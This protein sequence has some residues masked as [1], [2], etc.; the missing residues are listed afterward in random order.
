M[1]RDQGVCSRAVNCAVT[2]K[3]VVDTAISSCTE[4]TFWNHGNAWP[5]RFSDTGQN[6]AQLV[7]SGVKSQVQYWHM[8]DSLCVAR[9]F[10]LESAFSADSFMLFVHPPCACS[11]IYQH[12][13]AWKNPEHWQPYHCLEPQRYCDTLVG[14]RNWGRSVFLLL[15]M[16]APNVYMYALTLCCF[17]S[18]S[19]KLFATVTEGI[20]FCPWKNVPN[21][22][23]LQ[24]DQKDSMACMHLR[25]SQELPVRPGG[26]SHWPLTW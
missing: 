21:Q 20:Y 3:A 13:S 1:T 15:R 5:V 25:F 10:V 16:D 14:S 24:T 26:H 8:F 9:I 22:F 2:I 6:V 11:H 4:S 7:N 23:S 18:L 12:L 19:S 17:H